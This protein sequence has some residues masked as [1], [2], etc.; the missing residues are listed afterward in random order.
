MRFTKDSLPEI[1]ARPYPYFV[2]ETGSPG[3]AVK[4]LRTGHKSFYYRKK[5]NGKRVDVPLGRDLEIARLK[6]QALRAQEEVWNQQQ[7]TQALQQALGI[8][9]SLGDPTAALS[10][11]PHNEPQPQH[12][13]LFYPGVNLPSLAKRFL[14]EHVKQNLQPTTA[15]N[16]R[17]YLEKVCAELRGSGL[18][19]GRISVDVARQELK[20]YIHSM[21]QSTPIQ[22]NRIRETLSS[23]FKWGMYEDLCHASPV[24]GIRVFKEKPKTRR[25]NQAELRAFFNE[26]NREAHSPYTTLALKL[27]LATGLRAGEVLGIRPKHIDW[28]SN[29]LLIPD[30]KNGSPFIVPLTPLTARILDQATQGKSSGERVFKT[31]VYGLRQVSQRVSKKAAIPPCSTHDLRRTFGTL[32]GELGVDVRIIGRCLNHSSGGSV[33]TRVYALHDMLNEKLD[34]LTRLSERLLELGC[35]GNCAGQGTLTQESPSTEMEATENNRPRTT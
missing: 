20:S 5:A 2:I 16:Y 24:Y 23:C 13:P 9:P 11:V 26:L 12:N 21:K 4:V 3:F 31:S 1:P 7:G 32:L 19:T 17:I 22:A 33:T 27:V 18:V 8:D 35:M 14:E 15:R 29:K 6:Y 10:P 25:F 30:T 28:D 34:A